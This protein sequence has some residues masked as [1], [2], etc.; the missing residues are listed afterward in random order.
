MT[1]ILHIATFYYPHIGG[2]EVT[3]QQL[4]E[5]LTDYRNVVVCFS[6]DGKSHEDVI[7]NIHIYRVGVNFTILHQSVAF[8]YYH[9]V[10]RLIQ[11]YQPNF[12]HIH[13][14]NPFVYPIVTSLIKPNTKLIVHWH[15]DII[16]KGLAY[17]LVQGYETKLLNRADTIVA[18]SPYYVTRSHCL[19]QHKNKLQVLQSAIAPTAF[20]PTTDDKEKIKA[21]HKRYNDKK[22]VFFVGRHVGYKGIE[23][24]LK[25]EQFI[26]SDCAIV[27]AG[28]GPLDKRL[29][30]QSY[31]E[32]VHFIG[33]IS[34]DDLR[35]YLH[36]AD[37][38][39]FPS[40]NK[41]EA[42]GLALAEAMY[43]KAVPVTF[44]IEGSGVN[45]VS[46]A[47]ITGKQVPLGDI[48]GYAAAINELLTNDTL[49]QQYA[50]AAHQ[51]IIDNF[52]V[53]KAIL[54]AK[55]IYTTLLN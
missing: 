10:K 32:R 46:L 47:N 2:I 40:I 11:Q 7:N 36:A 6:N 39:A 51:R 3:A 18:T 45:W 42:F 24:L 44:S 34:H 50:E 22:I 53:E 5:G 16:G 23:C 43:C 27:I 9:T 30:A 41:A 38:F 12:I 20:V 13:C 33:H 52:T 29:L 37:I 14:P 8:G 15:S 28:K 26:Q 54:Q 31:S 55:Q 35:C 25:A 48:R 1:T 49:H 19:Q 17:N 21:I 4:A